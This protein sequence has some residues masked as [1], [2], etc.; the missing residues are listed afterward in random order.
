MLRHQA[1]VTID[2]PPVEVFAF[3]SDFEN[4]PRY[5]PGLLRTEKLTDGPVTVG[6]RYREVNRMIL[7]LTSKAEYEIV[8]LDA[9]KVIGFRGR[10]GPATFK[11]RWMLSQ[12][13]GGTEAT[14][15]GEASMAGPMR[16]IE[17]LVGRAVSRTFTGMAANLKRVLEAPAG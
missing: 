15:V 6:T 1:K 4:E 5:V 16:L 14:L 9:P 10:S 2:R 11:G 12:V 8:E 3:L 17:P 13:G 7:G